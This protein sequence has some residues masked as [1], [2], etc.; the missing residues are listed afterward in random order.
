MA[1]T[2]DYISET[3]SKY[4]GTDFPEN[5]LDKA[6]VVQREINLATA[7]TD[8]S[9]TTAFASGDSLLCI[10]VP[11]NTWVPAVFLENRTV[12]VSVG[13]TYDVGD[14]DD[15]NG[16]IDG[17]TSTTAG[18][19]TNFLTTEYSLAASGGKVYTT[20]D[21]IDVYMQD[22][23]SSNGVFVLTAVMVDVS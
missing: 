7:M 13:M 23:T 11:A 8:L 17:I 1:S 12:T 9:V 2:Y 16:F 5:A 21:T 14:G 6:Y 10:D 22:A 19:S 4:F 3:A 15:P 18:W 20:A